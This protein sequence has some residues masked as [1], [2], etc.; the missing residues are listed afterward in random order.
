MAAGSLARPGTTYGPCEGQCQHT[1]CAATKAMAA[2]A[3]A[4]C[5]QPI[6]YDTPMYHKPD[7]LPGEARWV[8]A[9]C[10]E[11]YYEQ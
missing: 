2:S 4:L 3:C 11:S 5:A 6:G 7:D 8:H 9:S 1:D 10:L